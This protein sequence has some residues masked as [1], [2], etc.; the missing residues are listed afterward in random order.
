MIASASRDVR[1]S[2]SMVSSSTSD[3]APDPGVG[4]SAAR[5][6]DSDWPQG[7][8]DAV[9]NAALP[10]DAGCIER[11]EQIAPHQHHGGDSGL[12]EQ[13]AGRFEHRIGQR[14]QRSHHM[15]GIQP[16]GLLGEVTGRCAGVHKVVRVGAGLLYTTAPAFGSLGSR[17]LPLARTKSSRL[18]PSHMAIAAATKT[19]E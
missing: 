4:R 14:R 1:I 18:T 12:V 11:L 13:A 2:R 10:A 17:S 19:D 3:R 6:L 9:G 15:I 7:L 5:A 16:P 8:V